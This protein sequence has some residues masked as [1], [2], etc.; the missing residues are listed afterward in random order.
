MLTFDP[1]D[2]K[3]LVDGVPFDHLARVRREQ[4]VCPTPAGA[5]YLS[6]FALVE[7]ALKDVDTYR[8]DLGA[9]SGLEGVEQV[10]DEEL[11]LSEL[12]EPRHGSVRRLFNATFG[13][14]RVNK[15]EP[16]VRDTCNGLVDR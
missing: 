12:L 2:P 1:H 3:H 10:P 11:F 13:P 6:R 15:L 16:F 5:W 14:H 9:L 4:P 8:A 7:A